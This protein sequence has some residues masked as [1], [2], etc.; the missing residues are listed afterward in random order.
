LIA[1]RMHTNCAKEADARLFPQPAKAL[2]V[3]C[4]KFC[5]LAMVP[6]DGGNLGCQSRP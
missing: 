3:V 2:E 1:L 5:N 4:V 6:S